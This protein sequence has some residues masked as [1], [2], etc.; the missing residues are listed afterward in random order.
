MMTQIAL[1][2]P[3]VL[4][5]SNAAANSVQLDLWRDVAM[6]P[7]MW[8]LIVESANDPVIV[9]T[10]DLSSPGP[11]IVYVNAAFTRLT[12]YS[13]EE[14]AGLSPRILQGPLTDR[15]EMHR[16]R[17]ELE[18]GR[19]FVGETINYT[20]DGRSYFME[21][22]VYGLSERCAE[23][24]AAPAFFV[25]V[26]RDVSARKQY[27][28]QIEEQTRLLAEANAQLARANERL[29]TL[30]LTDSLTGVFNHRA[31]WQK[32]E[33]EV[34]RAVRYGTPLSLLLIDVDHFKF[35]NDTF[36]HPAGDEALQ[37]LALLLQR[38]GRGSD[39]VARHGGEEFAILLPQTGQSGALALAEELRATVERSSWPLHPITVSLGIATTQAANPNGL[40]ADVVAVAADLMSQAD[41]AL[42]FSKMRGRN[43][44]SQW[45]CKRSE[46]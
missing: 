20:K 31:L 43:C 36:G 26:Q 38:Q 22:S 14:V 24:C 16:M 39:L 34:A 17:A 6:H 27:E 30:S 10:A 44:V 42:Y 12:G 4:P 35:Y 40:E 5:A 9:T 32:L 45:E 7:Q 2:A 23:G 11:Y 19:P 37:Q 3:A 25:A 13:A 21:W 41:Q 46:Q 8:K 29:E 28:R 15:A 33:A 1:P 18:A